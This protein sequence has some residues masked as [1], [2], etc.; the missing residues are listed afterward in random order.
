MIKMNC[1]ACFW[2]QG[3]THDFREM[4][5]SAWTFPSW[6]LTSLPAFRSFSRESMSPRTAASCNGND[7]FPYPINIMEAS[8]PNSV[9]NF[10]RFILRD[11]VGYSA[12]NSNPILKLASILGQRDFTISCLSKTLTGH[13]SPFVSFLEVSKPPHKPND[14]EADWYNPFKGRKL[15]ILITYLVS[16]SIQRNLPQNGYNLT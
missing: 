5:L 12:Y 14:K 8:N 9:W 2:W 6:M 13:W 7:D 11:R 10:V 15:S 16:T 3:D 4:P 1:H